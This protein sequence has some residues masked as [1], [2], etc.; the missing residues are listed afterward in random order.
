MLCRDI[1]ITNKLQIKVFL[2]KITNYGIK[3]EIVEKIIK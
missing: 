2:K 3:E 1:G